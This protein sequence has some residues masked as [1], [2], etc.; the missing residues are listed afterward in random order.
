MPKHL[1][2]EYLTYLRR[3]GALGHSYH[4]YNLSMVPVEV[5]QL[6]LASAD[7]RWSGRFRI[8][9]LKRS[10][11]YCISQKQEKRWRSAVEFT[12]NT[13]HYIFECSE[14]SRHPQSAVRSRQFS[15]ATTL[16]THHLLPRDRSN[17]DWCEF[18][19]I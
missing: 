11:I 17:A 8:F 14:R 10:P 15:A 1:R 18:K 9:P 6:A 4:R 2:A 7:R 13:T 19:R 5:E 12:R 16:P 3:V